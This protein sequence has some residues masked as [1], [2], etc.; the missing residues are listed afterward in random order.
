MDLVYIIFEK[1]DFYVKAKF[2]FNSINV[3]PE[4]VFIQ[5]NKNNITVQND[6][7]NNNNLTIKEIHCTNNFD[8]SQEN[9][10]LNYSLNNKI[11]K[12]DIANYSSQKLSC[13]KILI[14]NEYSDKRFFKSIDSINNIR[15]IKYKQSLEE[16]YK[17]YF[18]INK[19]FLKLKN[20]LTLIDENI[21]IPGNFIVK[22]NSGQ[23]IILTNN[24]FIFSDSAWYADG[25]KEKIYIKG[26]KESF[27]GGLIISDSQNQSFFKMLILHI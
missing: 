22:I 17:K 13:K 4:K 5:Q 15:N 10:K 6:S 18:V 16:N 3:E 26:K 11:N 27:G 7:I 12:F 14:V 9:I 19:N 8:N 21:F 1:N 25:N 2:L 23:S 20:N 24:A